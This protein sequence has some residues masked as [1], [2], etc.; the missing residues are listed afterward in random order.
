MYKKEN[1]HLHI[2]ELIPYN[3]I[4]FE[5]VTHKK[6]RS[7]ADNIVCKHCISEDF[8]KFTVFRA[9]NMTNRYMDHNKCSKHSF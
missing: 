7:N 1:A 8:L 2:N 6:R 4:E 9:L 3:S 5:N